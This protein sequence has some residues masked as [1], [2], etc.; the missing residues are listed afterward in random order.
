M[1]ITE[2]VKIGHL[3]DSDYYVE[4]AIDRLRANVG[5]SGSDKKVIM[6]TSSVPGEGKSFVSSSLWLSL[7]K[8]GK[9]TLFVDLDIRKSNIRNTLRLSFEDEMKGMSHYLAGISPID[10]VIYMT[11]VENAYI[12]PT[13]TLVNPSLL[14]E[15]NAL[16][17]FI[18]AVKDAFD[19]VILDTPP[20]TIVSDGLQIG[21]LADCA[22]LVVRAHSTTRTA[23]RDS[24]N[25][26]NSI[27]CPILGTVL[28]R[29]SEKRSNS[30]YYSNKYYSKYYSSEKESSKDK[31]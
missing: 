17:K 19:Y 27:S 20:L 6:V 7:A 4:N 25:Q 3:P 9:R 14:F 28:N 1:P 18:D 26:L 22:V 15:G 31:K 12:A 10:K 24:L 8:S 29:L 21:K 13:L 11:D 2:S 23:I 30:K 5:F 16:K